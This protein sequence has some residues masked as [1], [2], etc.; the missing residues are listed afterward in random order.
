MG[1]RPNIF[2]PPCAP[3]DI[4]GFADQKIVGAH[5][6]G[7]FLAPPLL[8]ARF[9]P[10]SPCARVPRLAQSRFSAAQMTYG[11]PTQGPPPWAPFKAPGEVFPPL[12]K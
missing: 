5:T 9:S 10:G 4:F 8:G 11:P 3:P 1:A 2:S 12:I 7:L 6:R